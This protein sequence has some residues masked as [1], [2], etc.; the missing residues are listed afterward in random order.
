MKSLLADLDRE[1]SEAIEG[2]L[3]NSDTMDL[4]SL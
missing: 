2:L 1:K 3:D 4:A